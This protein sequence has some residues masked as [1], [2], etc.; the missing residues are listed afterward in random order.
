M[1]LAKF[2]NFS[3]NKNLPSLSKLV[4]SISEKI[5]VVK[6]SCSSEKKSSLAL[7]A[8]F[9]I[10]SKILEEACSLNLAPTSSTTS[11]LVIGDA[12]AVSLMRKRRFKEIDFAKY[13]PGGSL[14]KRLLLKA[15]DILIKEKLP[16]INLSMSII[17]VIYEIS[18]Y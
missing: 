13:H 10:C 5:E 8:D 4:G 12:I 9:H 18:K 6:S 2:F 7:N 17:D 11:T 14:G 3:G 15:E 1:I 16:I